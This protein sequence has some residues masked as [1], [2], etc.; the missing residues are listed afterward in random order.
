M[1]AI[2]KPQHIVTES[3]DVYSFMIYGIVYN[4]IYKDDNNTFHI[5]ENTLIENSAFK[6]S[7]LSWRRCDELFQSICVTKRECI[8]ISNAML[9]NN[10]SE[11]AIR[12][13]KTYISANSSF[14]S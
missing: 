8:D 12:K 11:N 2:P 3:I 14:N 9:N 5:G 10:Q 7:F 4:F 1:K 13:N 6:N